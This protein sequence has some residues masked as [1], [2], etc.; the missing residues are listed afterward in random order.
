MNYAEIKKYDI[1]NGLGIRVSLFVSGCRHHCKGC[2]NEIAWD[3]SYG[4]A[5][6]EE[7]IKE[8][9]EAVDKP[10]IAGLTLLGGEPMEPENQPAV[11]KLLQAFHKQFPDKNVWCYTGFVLDDLLSGGRVHL[12]CTDELLSYIDILVDGPFIL[13][14]K[15]I[16]LK[17][18][19]SSNQ[20]I[21][22]LKETLQQG[23]VIE[24]DEWI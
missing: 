12:D 17:F 3:F 13:D 14:Q 24:Y 22:R 23:K 6:S 2:F 5:F 21:I 15:N 11:L 9:L 19:G 10:Y 4:K 7:T 16:Q 20:R 8:I 1:A 18:R